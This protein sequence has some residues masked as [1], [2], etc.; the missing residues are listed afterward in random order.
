M[1]FTER[2]SFLMSRAEVTQKELA[3][4]IGAG[5]STISAWVNGRSVPPADLAVQIAKILGTS[6]EYLLEGSEDENE[7]A[8]TIAHQVKG[9][10]I[11]PF[12]EQTNA[13]KHKI[14]FIPF[15]SEV[16][17]AAGSGREVEDFPMQTPLPIFTDLLAPYKPEQV[18]AIRVSGDSM[19]GIH[20]NDRDIVLFIPPET[21]GDGVYV[22]GTE[23]G[24]RVKRLEF[25]STGKKLTIHSENP[26][27]KDEEF[28]DAEI[29][30]IRIVGKVICWIHRHF[31]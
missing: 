20:I 2:M 1:N 24:L 17:V 29:D 8:I 10:K 14:V 13:G 11:F 28:I 6:V 5:Q 9:N 22:I 25:S 7:T 15:Y 12:S 21:Y 26:R 23:T 19:T 3:E 27:Y 16:E 31:Y 18:K 30:Q 4:Q